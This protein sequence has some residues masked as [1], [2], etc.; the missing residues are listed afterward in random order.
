[1]HSCMSLLTFD[2]AQA[3]RFLRGEH[4]AANLFSGEKYMKIAVLAGGYSHERDVSLMSGC[5][6]ANTLCSLGHSVA[7]ADVYSDIDET[8]IDSM[9]STDGSYTYTIPSS[10]PDLTALKHERGM[11][12]R[13]IGRNVVKLCSA[14]DITFLALHG[15]MGEDGRIQAILEC[16]GIKYTGSDYGPCYLAM[17]KSLAK[18][19]FS[20][21]GIPVPQGFVYRGENAQSI[22]LPCVVKPC[23]LG[24]SVG[25]S[26][27]KTASELEAALAK[28][29]SYEGDTLIESFVC[30]REFS[31]GVL[32]GKALPSIEIKPISGFYDYVGKYQSGMTEEICPADITPAQEA[33]IA[34]L[35]EAAY[36][37]LGLSVYARFD[38]ILDEKSGDFVCLEANT[39]PGMTP[40]SLIPQEAAAAGISYSE[41]VAKIVEL[42]LKK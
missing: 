34:E 3:D 11:G 31:C 35:S 16:N 36:R 40:A 30:G 20:A 27:V 28:A 29:S 24:S 42:S 26:I 18:V 14:A 39:L 8:K 1:M 13:L 37:A 12:E 23:S 7:L 41:L 2:H 32:D 9:F 22:S 6:I 19:I 5:K 25:V 15:G 4:Y 10:E 33:R 17:N 38:F 21:A